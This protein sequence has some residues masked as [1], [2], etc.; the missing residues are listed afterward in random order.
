MSDGVSMQNEWRNWPILVPCLAGIVTCVVHNYSLG[1]MIAPIEREF[2]WSRAEITTGPL[3]ISIVAIFT[4][5]LVGL[6]IDRLGPRRIAL[7]GIVL[8]CAALAFLGTAGDSVTSWWLRWAL[9]GLANM[10]I[11]T[12]VW[13][14]A[15]NATFHENRGKALAIVLSGTGIAAFTVPSL[16]LY[17]VEQGGWRHAYLAMAVISFLVAAPAILLLFRCDLDLP[18]RGARSIGGA[19]P[20]P[21]AGAATR[22]ALRSP[23]F[24]KLAAAIL[25]FT[26]AGS[27]LTAN[28]F[29]ILRSHGFDEAASASLAGV[30]G[31]GSVTGRLCGGYLLDRFDAKWVA[32]ISVL[33][34][35]APIYFFLAHPGDYPIAALGWFVIGL[36]MGAEVDTVAYLAARH[37]GMRSF[38]T[39]FGT[40]SGLTL[41]AAGL[42][43]L[44]ASAIYDARGSYDLALLAYIPA[45]LFTAGMFLM[46]GRYPVHAPD[47]DS[48][49]AEPCLRA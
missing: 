35:M 10:L 7:A 43:P 33:L 12:T 21:R 28:A 32:A 49:E 4:G 36:S 20:A 44:A 40:I 1:V 13:T 3:I 45:G 14:A 26:L 39:I 9:L 38:G 2:G 30:L 46:L 16:A 15:V 27:G 31:I 6:A 34:P 18:A 24:V 37:F 19:L 29:P 23:T 41:A 22:A 8:Y 11:L 47:G 42:A 17:L 48:D 25:V 5:P